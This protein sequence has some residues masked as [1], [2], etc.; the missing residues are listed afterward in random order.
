MQKIQDILDQS[1][2]QQK[3]VYPFDFKG[4]VRV[5]HNTAIFFF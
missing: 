3:S 1:T 5:L 4:F 2:V